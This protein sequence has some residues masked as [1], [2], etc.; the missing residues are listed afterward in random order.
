MNWVQHENFITYKNLAMFAGMMTRQVP[1]MIVA[2][3]DDMPDDYHCFQTP[4]EAMVW[5]VTHDYPIPPQEWLDHV[6]T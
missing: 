1:I 2:H 4:L 3:T 6:E 5:L